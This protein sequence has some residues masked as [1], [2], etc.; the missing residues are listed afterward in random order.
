MRLFVLAASIVLAQDL[1]PPKIL[2]QVAPEITNQALAYGIRGTVVIGMTIGIDGVP[3][4]VNVVRPIGFGLDESAMAAIKQ[5][6]FSPATVG[7]KPVE[8]A[9]TGEVNFQSGKPNHLGEKRRLEYNEAVAGLSSQDAGR[10]SESVKKIRS[11]AGSGYPP[12]IFMDG[13]WKMDGKHG[14]ADLTE[15]LKQIETA[16][17]RGHGQALG[18]LGVWKYEGRFVKKD[19][20]QGLQFME[21]GAIF[22]SSL[23]QNFLGQRYAAGTELPK[24]IERAKQMFRLCAARNDALCQ[25][26]LAG[27]ILESS[28]LSENQKVEAVAWLRVAAANNSSDAAEVLKNMEAS[29]TPEQRLNAATLQKQLS[30][31]R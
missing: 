8:A 24:N 15:G 18:L 17:S 31:A 30:P 21:E 27:L 22:G 5:W 16:A 12:A 28:P 10:V 3:H 1:R 4:T 6:K 20:K 13:V 25:F 11:L 9:T 29:L 14:P 7:G 2:K 26:R 19:I 23:A